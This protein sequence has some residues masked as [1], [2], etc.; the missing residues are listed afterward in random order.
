MMRI[1]Q[2]SSDNTHTVT[3]KGRFQWITTEDGGE[4]IDARFIHQ[5]AIFGCCCLHKMD[6]LDKGGVTDHR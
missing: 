6:N 5:L 3:T 4:R 2:Y 1:V